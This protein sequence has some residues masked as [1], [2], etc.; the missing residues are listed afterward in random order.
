MQRGLPNLFRT[1]LSYTSLRNAL[2]GSTGTA[3][4]SDSQTFIMNGIYAPEAGGYSPPLYD[5]YTAIYRNWRVNSCRV[6]VRFQNASDQPIQVSIVG[7]YD[8]NTNSP[9]LPV[10][11]TAYNIQA[12]N[13]RVRSNVKTL[14]MYQTSGDCVTLR[15]KFFPRNFVGQ[16]YF[17]S[18]NFSGNQTADPVRQPIVAVIAEYAGTGLSSWGCYAQ[19]TLEY[20]VTF[21]NRIATETGLYD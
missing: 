21:F 9:T 8:P 6:T 15:K 16:D 4:P 14:G 17:S 3:T 7:L 12:L 13:S 18:V 1:K 5:N 11:S 10:P 2:D 19:I 20:D